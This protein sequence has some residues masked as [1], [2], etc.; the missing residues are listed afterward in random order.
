[1]R[2][3]IDQI[4]VRKRVRHELGDIDGLAQ[5]LRDYGLIHPILVTDERNR[6]EYRLIAGE[7]RLRAAQSLGW[8]HIEARVVDG[9]SPA[10]QLGTE[11]DENLHRKPL[12]PDEIADA[13]TRLERMLRPSWIRRVLQAIGAFFRR[14]FTPR[15]RPQ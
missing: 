14:V 1:M 15:N 5:S 10:E 4:T 7:R 12:T 13:R 3:A 6:K 9:S 2:I 11:I 8:S